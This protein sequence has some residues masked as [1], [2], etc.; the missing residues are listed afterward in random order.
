VRAGRNNRGQLHVTE[1]SNSFAL[2]HPGRPAIIPPSTH[3]IHLI[4]SNLFLHRDAQGSALCSM[5]ESAG[6]PPSRF[7]L[8][9]QGAAASQLE[10]ERTRAA[11]S[12]CIGQKQYRATCRPM[13]LRG[14]SMDEAHHSAARRHASLLWAFCAAFSQ[15]VG[16][17]VRWWENLEARIMAQ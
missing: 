4:I 15:T 12:Y 13:L 2:T 16:T 10:R 8:S 3:P 9:S 6:F 7:W 14:S 17:A 1:T 5:Q 11:T